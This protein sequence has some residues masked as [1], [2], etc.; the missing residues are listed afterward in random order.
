M[1]C[2]TPLLRSPRLAFVDVPDPAV[3]VRNAAEA[4]RKWLSGA[5]TLAQ[6]T[7]FGIVG[8]LSSGLYAVA[9]VVLSSLGYL[10]ANLVGMVASTLLANELHR[11]LTFQATA[12]VGWLRAQLQGGGLAL[13]GLAATSLALVV[14]GMAVPSAGW[15]TQVLMVAVITGGMGL[16]RFAALRTWVFTSSRALRVPLAPLLPAAS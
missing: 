3:V 14:L 2:P 12:D 5:R 16:V 6:L 7:R 1:T 15:F 13:V 4:G 11:R 10:L 8:L 9:F